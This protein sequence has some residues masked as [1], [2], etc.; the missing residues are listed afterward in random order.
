[1]STATATTAP[2]KFYI[3]DGPSAD[4]VMDALKYAFVKGSMLTVTFD[5]A[6]TSQSRSNLR[7]AF[8]AQITGVRYESGEESMLVIEGNNLTTGGSFRGFYNAK[9]RKGT[10]DMKK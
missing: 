1:M 3:S 9:T 8:T 6:L 5:G 2:V 10:L 4:R 7:G